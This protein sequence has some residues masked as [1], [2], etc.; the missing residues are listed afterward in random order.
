MRRLGQALALCLSLTVS[1][2]C[3]GQTTATVKQNTNLQRSYKR[4][5]AVILKLNQGDS[6]TLI[7]KT[8]KSGF[9]HV[10]APN[11]TTKGWVLASDLDLTNSGG[12]PPQPPNGPP[13]PD[14]LAKLK[15]GRVTGTPQPLVINGKQVCGPEGDASDPQLKALD[16]EKNRTD[17]PDAST[18]IP[19]N[20]ENLRDLPSANVKNYEGAPVEVEGYL[21]NTIKI[22]NGGESTNCGLKND[23]EVDWHIYLTEQPNQ[24]ISKAVIV[25]T[26]PR[27]RPLHSWD[28]NA[29]SNYVNTNTKVRISGWLMYDIQ[30]IDVIGTERASVWEVHPITRIEVQDQNGNWKDVEQH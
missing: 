4:S 29:L 13:N 5:S 17:I 28:Y 21:S 16:G 23:D 8:K 12:N 9:Y 19:V 15:A 2:V 20:W 18:Y 11:G 14:L 30:H 22:E 1:L 3:F 26:T 25:E 7:S 24:P 10:I 27:T 6:V